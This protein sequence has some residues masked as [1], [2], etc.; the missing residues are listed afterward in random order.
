MENQ[1]PQA[2][3]NPLEKQLYEQSKTNLEKKI[4][5]EKLIGYLLLFMGLF[6]IFLSLFLVFNALRGSF[7]PPQVSNYKLSPI[8]LAMPAATPQIPEGTIL[9]EGFKFPTGTNTTKIQIPDDILNDLIGV[10]FY[11]LLMMFLASTGSKIAGI[12]VKMLK[13]IKVKV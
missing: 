8:E 3:N 12:G 9:P 7:K 4:A 6:M 10:S 13:D 2:P 1:N 5:Y 11:Y